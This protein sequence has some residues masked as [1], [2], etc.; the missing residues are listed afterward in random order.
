MDEKEVKIC[1]AFSK[2]TVVNVIEDF[3]NF[4]KLVYVEF[5]E[6]IG[7]IS[8]LVRVPETHV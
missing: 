3:E 4:F 6:F 7:R 5:L 1:Y 8:Y 2:M